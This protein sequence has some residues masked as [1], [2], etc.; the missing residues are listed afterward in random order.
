MSHSNLV[1]CTI[2]LVALGS[3]Q[4]SAIVRRAVAA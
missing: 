4:L 1:C 2:C 3:D